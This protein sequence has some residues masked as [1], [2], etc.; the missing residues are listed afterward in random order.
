MGVS[1]NGTVFDATTAGS[2]SVLYTFNSGNSPGFQPEGGV[3]LGTDGNFYGTTLAGGAAGCTFGCGIVFKY[4][5]NGLGSLYAFGGGSDG[6]SP[7]AAPVE[8]NDGNYYGTTSVGGGSSNCGTIYKMTPTGVLTTLY[9]FDNTHGCTS[10]SPLVLGT[11]GNFYGVTTFGGANGVGVVFKMTPAGALTV[12]FNFDG[13]HGEFPE[14]PLVQGTDG[15]FYGTAESGGT[16]GSGVVFKITP[17]GKLVTLHNFPMT[18][19]DG[20]A[21]TAGVVQAGDGN[22]YGVTQTGGLLGSG[23]IY[24]VNSSGKIYAD[25]YDF[26]GT[27]ASAP[28]IGMVQHTN[29]TFFGLTNQG[30]TFNAGTFYSFSV[31]GLNPFVSLV[32]SSG[33]VNA[34]IEIL[35]QGFTGTTGVSFNGTAAT[36]KVTSD[37]FLTATVPSG[38]TTGS[39][40]VTTPGGSLA[41][42]KIFRVIPAIKSFT[43]TSGAVGTSVAITGVSLTQAT[44]V[45]FGGVAATIFTVNSD[46]KVTATVPTGARTGKIAVTTPGGTATSAATFTVT[47]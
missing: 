31:P 26:D 40:T 32:T 14:S 25:L 4:S 12:I 7:I 8:G 1:G 34:K 46:S 22:F 16:L 42:N 15:N 10:N 2:P 44:R 5:S 23:T 20:Q 17:T 36:F 9:Q 24:R 38:A 39:V 13:T 45:T 18:S 43:P 35:G 37:T 29:G 19:T 41:S 11:D 28:Y 30:G 21:P 33:K 3:T 6:G 27:T 47:Q